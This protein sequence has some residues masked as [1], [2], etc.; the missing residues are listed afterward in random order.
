[1]EETAEKTFLILSNNR[2]CHAILI[3]IAVSQFREAREEI[4]DVL[5]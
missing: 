1:M 5:D 3:P 4:M 2:G